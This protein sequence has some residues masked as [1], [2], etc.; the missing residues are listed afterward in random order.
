MKLDIFKEFAPKNSKETKRLTNQAVIYTRVSSKD[1]VEGASL[2][3]QKKR[4]EEYAQKKGLDV[5]KYFG[6]TYESAKRDDRKEFQEM[7]TYVKKTKSI[8]YIIVYSYERFSRTGNNGAYICERL[9]E[10]HGISTVSVSQDIDPS[11]ITGSFQK[12]LYFLFGKFDNDLRKDKCTN[13]MR[14]RLR[15]G[16]WL[17]SL[18]MGYVNKN[19]GQRS[20][21]QDIKI[22]PEGKLIRKAFQLK[23]NH[24]MKSI[25]IVRKLNALGLKVS[26]QQLS[27]IFKNPFYC[28][29]IVNSLIPGEVIEGK[30]PPIVD[31]QTFLKANNILNFQGNNGGYQI[32]TVNEYLPLRMFVKCDR[33]QKPMTGYLVRKKGIHYYKCR[34]NG[35]RVNRNAETMEETFL[36]LLAKYQLDQ[37]LHS[38]LSLQMSK[39]FFEL[40]KDII[41]QASLLKQQRTEI[42]KKIE[43]VEE[44]FILDEIS[45]AAYKK[46]LGKYQEERTQILK[47][48]ENCGV[49]SSN[50]QECID[51]AI[52][53]SSNLLNIWKLADV[54]QK[55]QLQYLVFPEGV[56]YNKENDTFR[57]ARVN[58]YFSLIPSLSEYYHK[59]EKAIDVTVEQI[60]PWVELGGFEPPASTLPV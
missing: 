18:P 20:P 28:G 25:D 57:T 33:C 35:C 2:S 4:C 36:K 47:E 55:Q 37:Q 5:V 8:S 41:A 13:G 6:G 9:Y 56:L 11:S 10:Q 23:A 31:K 34:T 27:N 51:F 1:Q 38:V 21:N 29:L 39:L 58:S 12:D 45:P 44:K 19:K 53:L 17:W 15:E 30:H 46:Y 3:S 59:K 54:T 14:D 42:N 16:Y 48:I 49:N 52:E 22:T 40:N 32:Q 50:L 26:N 24:G 7:L 43:K 60:S